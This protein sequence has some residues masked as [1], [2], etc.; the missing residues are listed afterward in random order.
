[1]HYMLKFLFFRVRISSVN[2]KNKQLLLEM[3]SPPVSLSRSPPGGEGG[4]VGESSLL[5]YL[6]ITCSRS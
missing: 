2:F 5:P 1:M 6:G 4:G 3:V